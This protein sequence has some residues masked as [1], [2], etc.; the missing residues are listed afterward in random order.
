VKY[1]WIVEHR[2]SWPI[3]VMCDVLKV[4]GS[5]FYAWHHRKAFASM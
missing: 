4:S 2:A 1:A 3:A 5:G